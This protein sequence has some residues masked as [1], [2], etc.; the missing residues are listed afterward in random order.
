[1]PLHPLPGLTAF[2]GHSRFRPARALCAL[3]LAACALP[4]LADVPASEYNALM[5]LYNSTNGAGWRSNP[6]WGVLP[7]C[8]G[9]VSTWSGVTCDATDT[10]V[11]MLY[12][13]FTNLTGPL[14]ATLNQLTQLQSFYADFNYFNGPIPPLAGLAQLQNFNATYSQLTGSIPPLT[15]LTLLQNFHVDNNRLTG[16]I[17][18]LTG[19]TAL[20]DFSAEYNQLTGSIPSLTGLTALQ[21]F[22]VNDN[23]LTGS[24]PS[25]DGLPALSSIAVDANQ[26]TGSVPAPSE[27]LHTAELC[28]NFLSAPSPDD[29]TWSAINVTGTPDWY[30][31][32][33]AP[34]PVTINATAVF[35]PAAGGGT[36]P[37]LALT[38]DAPVNTVTPGSQWSV[39]TGAH[40]TLTA[41]GGATPAG[42]TLGDTSLGSPD[43]VS[44]FTALGSSAAVFTSSMDPADIGEITDVSQYQSNVVVTVGLKAITL[45]IA[46]ANAAV[47]ALHPLGLGLLAALLGLGAFAPRRRG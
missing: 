26:L 7:V 46:N 17:P 25:L 5:D 12:L 33:S 13:P 44:V 8:S 23:Y 37:T 1:M 38:C 40:C 30:T 21:S 9:G 24:I 10:H 16:P 43:P 35:S 29:A 31:D 28:P 6:G 34:P 4:A 45:P 32:C 11:T 47:P 22:S 2:T 19:L 27:N 36:L 3:L 14:P 42:Y 20:Q 39:V 15:G 41:T 18:S